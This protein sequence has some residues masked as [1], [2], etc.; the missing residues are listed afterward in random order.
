MAK[1]HNSNPVLNINEIIDQNNKPYV[2]PNPFKNYLNI[3]FKDLHLVDKIEIY[4]NT[5]RLVYWEE[6]PGQ[7]LNL[8]FLKSGTYIFKFYAD[9]NLRTIKVIKE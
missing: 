9:K 5:G 2:F 6:N 1:Y 3:N 4:E 8:S 7:V